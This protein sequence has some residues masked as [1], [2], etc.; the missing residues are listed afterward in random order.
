MEGVIVRASH[1]ARRIGFWFGTRRLAQV[2]QNQ[3][4]VATGKAARKINAK[5]A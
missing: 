5:Y 4:K 2:L 3:P 1:H